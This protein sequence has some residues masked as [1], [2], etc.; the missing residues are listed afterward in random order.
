MPNASLTVMST[1]GE[2]TIPIPR[3]YKAELT[4]PG[5]P[6]L[7]P[8]AVHRTPD[9][10]RDS[11]FAWTLTH[12]ETGALIVRGRTLA[13]TVTKGEARLM[14]A[15]P[16]RTLKAIDKARKLGATSASA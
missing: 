8:L 11:R 6:D 9:A 13:E 15:G 1:A 10:P 12:I 4:L 7:G 2:R 16:E 5:F 3:W 14:W